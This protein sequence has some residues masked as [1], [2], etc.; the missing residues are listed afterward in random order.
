MSIDI[1]RFS[2]KMDALIVKRTSTDLLG[3]RK[4]SVGIL[5]TL[6]SHPAREHNSLMSYGYAGPGSVAVDSALV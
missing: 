4:N 3:P 2:K 1:P 6:G 5:P